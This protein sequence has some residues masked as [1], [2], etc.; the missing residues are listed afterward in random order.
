MALRA[1][2]EV[3]CED[4]G[5]FVADKPPVVGTQGPPSGYQWATIMARLAEP[6]RGSRGGPDTIY[7]PIRSASSRGATF[8]AMLQG[9][10]R[11]DGL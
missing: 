3:S 7:G 9:R 5:P 1:R 10:S 4:A 2:T 8:P 6:L 11:A